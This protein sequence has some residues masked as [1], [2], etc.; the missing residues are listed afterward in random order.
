M[1]LEEPRRSSSESNKGDKVKSVK[2]LEKGDHF[3]YREEPYR[4]IKKELVAVGTH[5]HTKIKVD[6]VGVFSGKQETINFAQHTNVEDV[7]IIRKVGQVIANQ[8]GSLQVMDLVSYETHQAK[9]G[10]ELLKQ[11]NEGDEV[12]FVEFNGIIVLEKRQN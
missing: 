12:T 10:E 5:S 8:P 3:V 11:L 6:A 9:A 7:V 2:E 4:V 1:T